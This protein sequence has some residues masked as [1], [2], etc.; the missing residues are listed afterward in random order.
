MLNGL[1]R[2]IFSLGQ[3]KALAPDDPRLPEASEALTLALGAILVVG[4]L[5]IAFRPAKRDHRVE[6]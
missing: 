1:M 4:I 2:G 5:L 3:M 6:S